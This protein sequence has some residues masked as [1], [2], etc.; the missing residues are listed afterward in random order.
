MKKTLGPILCFLLVLCLSA[1]GGKVSDAKTHNVES[2]T[3]SQQDIAAAI[4][5]IKKEFKSNWKGK[6]SV[7]WKFSAHVPQT[8]TNFLLMH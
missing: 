2:E 3:Y 6:D 4:D 5:V 8:G 7:S 1:C